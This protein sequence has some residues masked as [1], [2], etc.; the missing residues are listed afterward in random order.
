M[1]NKKSIK[2]MENLVVPQEFIERAK[3]GLSENAEGSWQ[4]G[5]G[6]FNGRSIFE[7]EVEQDGLVLEVKIYAS[8]EMQEEDDTNTMTVT[9]S[10]C[11]F[12][13]KLFNEDGEVDFS[14]EFEKNIFDQLKEVEGEMILS[15]N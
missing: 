11:I 8:V 4:F 12:T 15:N 7:S 9:I 13:I 2:N 14:D 10:D 3:N 5:Q 1:L 6:Y